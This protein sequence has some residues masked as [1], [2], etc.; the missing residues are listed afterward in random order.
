MRAGECALTR[1]Y[2]DF[3]DPRQP[4]VA[5]DWFNARAYCLWAGKRLPTEAEWEKASRGTD[6]RTYPWGEERATCARAALRG[7]E[8]DTTRAVGSFDPGAW[9]LYDMA[10]N[11]YEF[12]QDW[13]S[14]CYRGCTGEC[15]AECDGPDP[16]GPCAGA[17]ECPGRNRRI[18]KG[19]SWYWG[20]DKARSAHRR[21]MR[22]DHHG[23]RLGFRCAMS[24]P[25]A[26]SLEVPDN[27]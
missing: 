16:Q 19:G 4:V 27:E 21:P 9:G 15:G 22:A 13:Y 23:H 10:G 26:A 5:I 6:G 2:D 25:A 3:E 14:S 1:H 18:L 8:P 20:P 7:C 17:D 12:V 24:A 11:A